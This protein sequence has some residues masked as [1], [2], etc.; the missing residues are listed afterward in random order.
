[1]KSFPTTA[2]HV[3]VI[4]ASAEGTSEKIWGFWVWI[5]LK[6]TNFDLGKRFITYS[7]KRP[8]KT[9]TLTSNFPA[10]TPTTRTTCRWYSAA[11]MARARKNW[12]FL[13]R[14]HQKLSFVCV[15]ELFTTCFWKCSRITRAWTS[16]FRA[17]HSVLH[18][19]DVRERR[20]REWEKI[21]DFGVN[22]TKNRVAYEWASDLQFVFENLS[23]KPG[24]G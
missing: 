6:L 7:R 20:R 24:H 2:G 1:M 23:E 11:P 16:N 19:S 22:F 4:F 12:S 5:F 13:V 9:R 3:L 17:Q 18:R 14:V 21:E 10:Q 15:S 8:R